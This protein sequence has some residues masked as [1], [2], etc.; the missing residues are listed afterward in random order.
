[1]QQ[2]YVAL[3]KP[4]HNTEVLMIQR[5]LNTIR[6][7][8]LHN[9]PIVREDGYYGVETARAVKAF[10]Q[11]CNITADGKYG[12]QT[13]RYLMQK[14]RELPSIGSAQIAPKQ[15]S[16]GVS[17]LYKIVDQFIEVV[18]NFYSSLDSVAS[19]IAKLERPTSA[20]IFNSFRKSVESIDPAMKRLRETLS[21]YNQYKAGSTIS[22]ET[23]KAANA[24]AKNI[25]NPRK[26][27]DFKDYVQGRKAAQAVS[28]A[29]ANKRLTDYYLKKGMSA[30]DAV[31]NN[32]KQYDFISKI[33]AKLKSLGYS[34]KIDLS[35]INLSK[36]AKGVG[37]V[38]FVY[39]LKD[40]IWDIFHISELF[41][42]SKKEAWIED[43]KKD[44]YA[45]LDGL[46]VACVSLL[47]AKLVV[48][49]G[50]SIAVIAGASMSTVAI[51][52]AVAII[53]LIIGL[54]ICYC[55]S[56]YDISFSKF[57]FEDCAEFILS[58]ISGAPVQL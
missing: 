35:K 17:S 12:P 1:M 32:L 20:T 48:A 26:N 36:A 19:S 46:I 51:A 52:I 21:K 18:N 47:L 55:L 49:I 7:A 25:S 54:I 43:L 56:K 40:I 31:L 24:Y 27:F 28:K 44:C 38:A 23:R 50:G 39:S 3:P 6:S 33:I 42:E 34:G 2:I 37:V 58:K 29:N 8:L 53:A 30:K 15:V 5:Q 9:L 22:E 13:H 14:I 57:I 11:A 16:P 45:F 41:D 4:Q 10:Q